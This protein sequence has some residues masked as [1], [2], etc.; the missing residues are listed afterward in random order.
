MALIGKAKLNLSPSY[1]LLPAAALFFTGRKLMKTIHDDL[2][3]LLDKLLGF[4]GGLDNQ[5]EK[6][7]R[8]K[9]LYDH[10]KYIEQQ[11]NPDYLLEVSHFLR[12]FAYSLGP[13][14]C[15]DEGRKWLLAQASD[16]GFI[17]YT[18]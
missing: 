4:A 18:L 16:L 5:P 14:D 9:C 6:T 11:K 17:A 7:A 2:C 3:K 8:Q 1:A 12:G 10:I 13:A 15:S